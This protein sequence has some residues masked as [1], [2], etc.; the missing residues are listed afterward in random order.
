MIYIEVMYADI[1][2]RTGKHRR[3][4]V[5]LGEANT[6]QRD[7]VLFMIL[8]TETREEKSRKIIDGK[9]YRRRYQWTQEDNYALL[10]QATE[11]ACWSWSIGEHD[12][13]SLDDPDSDTR[14]MRET[15]PYLPPGTLVFEGAQID[16]VIWNTAVAEFERDMH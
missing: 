12:W 11:V 5:T 3:V 13:I 7:D 10:I 2:A 16:Q 8:S 1:D 6:L 14:P 15:S 9:H 4:R